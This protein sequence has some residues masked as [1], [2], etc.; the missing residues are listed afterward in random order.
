M[1]S[2]TEH[3]LHNDAAK[4]GLGGGSNS[5]ADR[6]AMR[7]L[8]GPSPTPAMKIRGREE[9][10]RSGVVEL[11]VTPLEWNG[12]AHR[13]EY[14]TRTGLDEDTRCK[15]NW[16]YCHVAAPICERDDLQLISDER[17]MSDMCKGS[18]E[19]LKANMIE[20]EGCNAYWIQ[21]GRQRTQ[22]VM[23][24]SVLMKKSTYGIVGLGCTV[25]KVCHVHVGL[26]RT[27]C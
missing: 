25:H 1:I 3:T 6:C 22:D 26:W 18:D 13:T 7:Q 14:W 12:S 5:K 8:S 4:V 24:Q 27:V 23:K 17:G 9:M 16:T 19:L 15:K 10:V 2:Q 21:N 20:W 11:H